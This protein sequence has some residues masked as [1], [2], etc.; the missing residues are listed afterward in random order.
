M[1]HYEFVT[2]VTVTGPDDLTPERAAEMASDD[3]NTR[4]IHDFSV[5]TPSGTIFYEV[6]RRSVHAG[7]G[8]WAAK[9]V[10]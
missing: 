8:A 10:A 9:K 7:P 2:R 1:K 5:Y 6:S 3:L 4:T